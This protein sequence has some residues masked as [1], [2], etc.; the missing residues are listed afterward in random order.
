MSLNHV[1]IMGRMARDPDVKQTK[2]GA[3]VCN[4]TLAVDRD[5]KNGDERVTDWIDCVCF[6]GTADFAGKY[7]TKGRNVVVVGSLQSDKWQ[8][9]DGNNRINWKVNATKVYFADSKKDG[10]GQSAP[11]APDVSTGGYDDLG[12]D[13]SDLPF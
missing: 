11:A 2:S 10:A 5:Y 1:F 3:P 6:S 12:K 7:L 13:E 8:D 4:F 9:K